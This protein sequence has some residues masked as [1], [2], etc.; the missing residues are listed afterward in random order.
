MLRRIQKDVLPS[1]ES[2]LRKTG[3]CIDA[4]ITRQ[5]EMRDRMDEDFSI[6][7]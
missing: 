1:A 2:R 7:R 6:R 5:L 3:I 4:T